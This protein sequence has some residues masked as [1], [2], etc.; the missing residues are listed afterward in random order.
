MTEDR[1]QT[2]PADLLAP[3]RDRC[4]NRS[5]LPML[6]HRQHAYPCS[7]STSPLLRGDG[8]TCFT[9]TTCF[10]ISTEQRTE[11]GRRTT[12]SITPTSVTTRGSRRQKTCSETSVFCLSVFW[13]L[14]LVGL[15]RVERPTS[16]LSGVRSDQLSYRPKIR[17]QRTD[18]RGQTRRSGVSS[19]AAV[20]LSSAL[21]F[22]SS[23][24]EGMRGRRP[25]PPVAD[26]GNR[27]EADRPVC[28]LSSALCPLTFRK[29]VIQPQ[30]PLRLP[31]YDF[32]PV[33]D[34]TVD[35]CPLTVSAPA[36]GQTNSHGVTGGVYK[37]RERI[38][39]GMLIRDY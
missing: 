31:C 25:G 20:G 13:H 3:L 39:R 4:A 9:V 1:C 35:G 15:G 21:R 28:S 10:T 17:D 37:A 27:G 14:H 7:R 32:T 16:R 11:D 19:A 8:R 33:A 5:P 30:V 24:L 34:L 22:L 29:E 36:S 18:D 38:H 26:D 23:D 12:R 6:A 2:I